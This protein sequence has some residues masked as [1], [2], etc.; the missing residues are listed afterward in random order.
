[1]KVSRKV[2]SVLEEESPFSCIP[3]THSSRTSL[4]RFIQREH[5]VL[6]NFLLE[7]PS[8]LKDYQLLRSSRTKVNDHLNSLS[9]LI[10]CRIKN[11]HKVKQSKSKREL[12]INKENWS[13]KQQGLKQHQTLSLNSSEIS[14]NQANRERRVVG[15]AHG[16]SLQKVCLTSKPGRGWWW[17]LW[18]FQSQN[19]S[20]KHDTL[21]VKNDHDVRDKKQRMRRQTQEVILKRRYHARDD[22]EKEG[23][24]FRQKERK[25]R[26]PNH[27][28]MPSILLKKSNGWFQS[29]QSW[30]RGYLSLP[31]FLSLDPLTVLT[32]VRQDFLHSNGTCSSWF[33]SFNDDEREWATTNY[34]EDAFLSLQE[35]KRD[36]W[37]DAL[38]VLLLISSPSELS[39]SS[40]TLSVVIIRVI[41]AHD[42]LRDSEPSSPNPRLLR[43]RHSG[44]PSPSS[45]SLSV[46]KPMKKARTRWGWINST[47]I[48]WFYLVSGHSTDFI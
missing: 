25:K 5:A 16:M 13:E 6:F 15:A 30:P 41:S 9:S 18:T 31:F 27:L 11:Q 42:S 38:N 7:I 34:T 17:S 36:W 39:S 8:K 29:I 22:E 46:M 10:P 20:K 23:M 2:G 4:F 35:N 45:H 1:M 26:N 28:L 3:F 37:K 21:S 24:L 33:T 14:S 40:R 12:D 32:R 43:I 47:F 19:L 44:V 48:L